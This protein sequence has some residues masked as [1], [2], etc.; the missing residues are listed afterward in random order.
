MITLHTLFLLFAATFSMSGEFREYRTV[1]KGNSL[2]MQGE[3]FQAEQLYRTLPD[4][5]PGK[6]GSSP[7]LFN[8]AGALVRQG[9]H[10]EARRIYRSIALNPR[11]KHLHNPSIYNEGTSLA[12]EGIATGNLVLK[13]ELLRQA[14]LRYTAVLRSDPADTDARIN[15]EI[16]FRM[17]ETPRSSSSRQPE[18]SRKNGDPAGSELMKTAERILEN[19]RLQENSL[20]RKIPLSRARESDS[21]KNLKD[22]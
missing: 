17:L 21:G 8:L 3:Y 6:K 14:L 15:Y 22:W 19:A 12:M 11:A 7:A 10:T 2:Y 4:I 1:Q 5:P 13:R 16:V 9:K 20:M 18:N